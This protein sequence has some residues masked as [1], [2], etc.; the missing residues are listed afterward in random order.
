MSSVCKKSQNGFVT[1][2][3]EH[4]N[5]QMS[6][7]SKLNKFCKSPFASAIVLTSNF[8][9]YILFLFYNN[10]FEKLHLHLKFPKIPLIGSKSTINDSTAAKQL[11]H[12]VALCA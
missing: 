4:T 6:K 11:C 7:D 10:I 2:S 3:N 5:L 9:K 12:R 8:L 1:H